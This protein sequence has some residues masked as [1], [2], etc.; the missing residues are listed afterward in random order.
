MDLEQKKVFWEIRYKI[1]KYLYDVYFDFCSVTR[2]M[3]IWLETLA[4]FTLTASQV[5]VIVVKHSR[6]RIGFW[7]LGSTG[8]FNPL[9]SQEVFGFHRATGICFRYTGCWI[10]DFTFKSIKDSLGLL[11]PSWLF[12]QL[13]KLSL[14]LTG[15]FV[16]FPPKIGKFFISTK[17]MSNI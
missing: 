11:K 2:F 6:F 10:S 8:T 13:G 9:P 15:L 3:K 7:V 1:E 4:Y 5:D 12:S 16:T 14:K 17:R